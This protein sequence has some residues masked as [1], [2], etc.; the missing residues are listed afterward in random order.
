VEGLSLEP[1]WER[2]PSKKFN[3]EGIN[4]SILG[5]ERGRREFVRPFDLSWAREIRDYCQQQ[6]VSIFLK[7]VGRKPSEDGKNYR[8][9]DTHGGDWNEWPEKL[10]VREMPEAF[11][12]ASSIRN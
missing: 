4:W 7:L 11:R 1:L 10:R 9:S 2:I 5:G 3:F 6:G 12:D 8:A